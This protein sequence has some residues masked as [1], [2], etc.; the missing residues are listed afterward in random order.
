MVIQDPE[1]AF[2][3]SFCIWIRI[4]LPRKILIIFFKTSGWPFQRLNPDH[5]SE[6][7]AESGSSNSSEYESFLDPEACFIPLKNKLKK[8]IFNFRH[9]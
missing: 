3:K 8:I 9:N 5:Y 4:L 7:G 2:P 1:P 6:C